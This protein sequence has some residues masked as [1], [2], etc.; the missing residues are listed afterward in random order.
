[1]TNSKLEPSK[2]KPKKTIPKPIRGRYITPLEKKVGAVLDK[3]DLQFFGRCLIKYIRQEAE[4]DASKTHQVPVTEDFY[5][6]FSYRVK[7]NTIEVSSSWPW[8]D[9]ITQGRDP[10][11]MPWLT[12]AQGVY[13]VPLR[14]AQGML[15]IRSTPLTTDKA[16]IHP[17]IAR[18][19]FIE[20]A[21][22][23]AQKDCISSFLD[24]KAN[25][26]MAQAFK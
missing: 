3:S 8:I 2:P 24:K 10:Y 17:A 12:Q 19:T 1:M 16:W 15:V 23:R 7:G 14:D 20:R 26:I 5:K 25:K 22:R 18:H 11:P 9:M 4:K 13:K 21:F 6:S